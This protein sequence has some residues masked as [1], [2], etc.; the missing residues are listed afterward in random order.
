MRMFLR[1]L[2]KVS[3]E[4]AHPKTLRNQ[5]EHDPYN[6]QYH[7]PETQ[8]SILVV[9][10][11]SVLVSVSQPHVCEVESQSWLVDIRSSFHDAGLG[12]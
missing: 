11:A 2:G 8:K 12:D 9:C 4:Y 7:G 3:A 10:L 1:P 6:R 5:S